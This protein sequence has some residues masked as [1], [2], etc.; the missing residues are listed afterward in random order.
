MAREKTD[1]LDAGSPHLHPDDY[2]K[3]GVG[4]F[5]GSQD[6]ADMAGAQ[7]DDNDRRLTDAVRS[8]LHSDAALKR[9]DI[10]I[11]SKHA[12]LTGVVGNRFERERAETLVREVEGVEAIHNDIRVQAG[13]E[14]G[15]PI[16]T[17]HEPG[18][19]KTGSTQRS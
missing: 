19:N 9:V 4:E 14:E 5:S 3:I 12:R 17:T 1:S 11:V 18:A 10:R 13:S 8:R 6:Y 2:Q 7:P 15:G 16:L